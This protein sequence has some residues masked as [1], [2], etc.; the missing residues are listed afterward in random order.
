MGWLAH[1]EVWIAESTWA[2]PAWAT[3]L[4]PRGFPLSTSHGL[5]NI[6]NYGLNRQPVEEGNWADYEFFSDTNSWLQVT[7]TNIHAIKLSLADSDS[8]KRRRKLTALDISDITRLF[9]QF[10]HAKDVRNLLSG[11]WGHTNTLSNETV[12]QSLGPA[13]LFKWWGQP[14]WATLIILLD[15]RITAVICCFC[16]FHLVVWSLMI[17]PSERPWTCVSLLRAAACCENLNMLLYEVRI[18]SSF[19][20]IHV[21]EATTAQN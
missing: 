3:R 10:T 6:S 20:I 7:R 14:E 16:P 8:G 13:R 17:R 5:L 4:T 21:Y 12:G 11:I 15:A 18:F 2:C 19:L 9:D 1:S